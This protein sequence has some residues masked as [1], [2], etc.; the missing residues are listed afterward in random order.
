MKR[1]SRKGRWSLR[2]AAIGGLMVVAII[3]AIAR[4]HFAHAE[5]KAVSGDNWSISMST[6]Y[7]EYDDG[8][9]G[10]YSEWH[11]PDTM[12]AWKST[13]T[14]FIKFRVTY[15]NR[16]N[17]ESYA[18]GEL[19][20]VVKNPIP[21]SDSNNRLR[22]FTDGV[23]FGANIPGVTRY[24][25]T[26]TNYDNSAYYND[27][28]IFTNAN[29][30]EANTNMEGSFDIVFS[31][32]QMGAGAV[33]EFEN[34]FNIHELFTSQATLNDTVSSNEVSF[35]FQ[36]DF[37]V[38][39]R[40]SNFKIDTEVEKIESYDLIDEQN[41]SDYTWVIYNY[42]GRA[43][44]TN[45]GN[46][47]CTTS[48]P[49]V[50]QY[51]R[52][53]FI[54]LSSYHFTTQLPEGAVAYDLGGN[55]LIPDANNYVDVPIEEAR[56]DAC[57]RSWG[58]AYHTAIIGYPKS[59]YNADD[60]TNVISNKIE[61]RGVYATET[62]E[63]ALAQR[64]TSVDLSN[65]G[66]VY[67]GNDIEATKEYVK[68]TSAVNENIDYEMFSSD[69]KAGRA[70]AEFSNK[71]TIKNVSSAY[72]LRIGD[73]V[74]FYS[75]NGSTQKLG[76]YDYYFTRVGKPATVSGMNGEY[77][78]PNTHYSLYVRRRGQSTFEKYGDY[79]ELSN[80]WTGQYIE[81]K[82]WERIVGWYIEIDNLNTSLN[83]TEFRTTVAFDSRSLPDSGIA[84]NFNFIEIERNGVIVNTPNESSYEGGMTR[85]DIMQY[86][87]DTYGRLRQHAV[88]SVSWG[89]F[90]LMDINHYTNPDTSILTAPNYNAT[91]DSFEGAISVVAWGHDYSLDAF[92]DWSQIAGAYQEKDARTYMRYYFLLPKG[93]VPTM[94]GDEMVENMR[95]FE[96]GN[97]Q[98]DPC[99]KMRDYRTGEP[100]LSPS[101][102]SSY[103]REH[104]SVAVLRNW[105]GTGQYLIRVNTDFSDKP[106]T[107]YNDYNAG[108]SSHGLGWVPIPYRVSYDDYEQYGDSYTI[109]GF[110]DMQGLESYDDSYN[111]IY[112]YSFKDDGTGRTSDPGDD[113][114]YAHIVD[115]DDDGDTEEY[116]MTT[117]RVVSL[118]FASATVQDVQ[119]T[120][121]GDVDN[122][123]VT[124]EAMSSLGGDYN[125]RLRV[126]SGSNQ[127]K[128]V[129]LY[130]T[131]ENAFGE[132]E[133]WNGA[134]TGIDTSFADAQTDAN[135]NPVHVKT[136]WSSSLNP[137]SLSEDPSSW[138]EYTTSTD[139]TQVRSLAF[140]FLNQ[141][142]QPATLPSDSNTY[143]IINM[144][145]PNDNNISTYAYNG[146][147][148]EWK[149]IDPQTGGTA[150][151]ITG[152]DSN[153]TKI[154]LD[155]LFDIHV[156]NRWVD[157]DNERGFRPDSVDFVLNRNGVQDATHN[158][159]TTSNNDSFDFEDLHLY[160]EDHYVVLKPSVEHYA[161]ESNYD[162]ATHTYVFTHTL[163]DDEDI[164]IVHLWE[165][166]NNA[167][168]TRPASVT[169]TLR[170]GESPITRTS[171][172]NDWTADFL[173]LDHRNTYVLD[174]VSVTDYDTTVEYD[175]DTQTYTYTS[176]LTRK[177]TVNIQ[178]IWV[179]DD[180]ARN[181]RP[182]NVDYV[183]SKTGS[184]DITHTELL[185]SGE[186]TSFVGLPLIDRA[187]YSVPDI[188]IEHYSTTKSCS[189]G[190]NNELN[191]VFTSTLLDD[192]DIHVVHVWDDLN[193]TYNLR[194]DS[195]SY[196]L[197]KNDAVVDTGSSEADG[198]TTDFVNL[199]RSDKSQYVVVAD[200]IPNYTTTVS[201]DSEGLVYTFTSKLSKEFKVNIQQVW[202]DNNNA[203]NL[204]PASQVYTLKKGEAGAQTSTIS[205]ANASTTSF[206]GLP[207]IDRANYSVPDI[208]I[209]HYSTTKSCT[210]GDDFEINCVFT[211][212]LQ[213]DLDIHV[214]HNWVDT[215]FESYRPSSVSYT[216]QKGNSTVGTQNASNSTS[217]KTDFVNLHRPDASQYSIP[218]VSVPNY[219]TTKSFDENTMTYTFTSTLN[220]PL[221]I[222]VK[223][224]WVDNNNERGLRPNSIDYTLKKTGASDTVQS[225]NIANGDSTTDFTGLQLLDKAKF[226]VPD[227]TVQYYD[228][229]KSFDESTMT[230]TFKSTLRA[231][232]ITVK[233]VWVDNNNAKGLR[234]TTT[235]Y[236]LVRNN[237]SESAHAMNTASGDSQFNFT[238]VPSDLVND[239]S[240]TLA[241]F[242]HYST[243][244]SVSDDKLTYTF[245]STLSD[246]FAITINQI[247]DDEDN[248]RGLRPELTSYN[249]Q[250]DGSTVD[251]KEISAAANG[252]TS[253]A[254]LPLIDE[255]KY[256]VLEITVEHY[257]TTVS[258]DAAT[259]TYTFT[260]VLQDNL[261]IQIVHIW[262]DGDNHFELRPEKV[263]YKLLKNDTEVDSKEVSDENDWQ[264]KVTNLHMP[265][266]SQYLVPTPEIENYTTTVE[267][268]PD[269]MTYTFT[270]ALDLVPVNIKHVWDDGDNELDS[271][272]DEVNSELTRNDE[273]EATHDVDTEE[274]EDEFTI[275]QIPP[276]L[277]DEY[278]AKLSPIDYYDTDVEFDPDTNTYIFVS[279]L[280]PT[281]IHVRN[282]WVDNS[283]ENRLRPDTLEFNLRYEKAQ[284]VSRTIDT[285]A[286]DDSFAFENL[287]EFKAKKYDVV[288]A[289]EIENYTTTVEFDEA[290]KTYVFTHTVVLAGNPEDAN[291]GTGS[292]NSEDSTDL[293]NTFANNP[294]ILILALLGFGSVAAT[295]LAITKRRQ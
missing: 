14:K 105:H 194:P 11:I 124:D 107:S 17:S 210:D 128:N 165:D 27:D 64:T 7:E 146:F 209:E 281:E 198:W 80:G 147:R 125:Y 18:P 58:T 139:K 182:E 31:V 4:N 282:I 119:S 56:I 155:R 53:P 166:A 174:D 134:F 52:G 170:G 190:E 289:Q 192:L 229:V 239:Y 212:K 249:L 264:T 148:S 295:T 120:V 156:V 224:V 62:D 291:G 226:S 207:L 211:S 9:Y 247:W 36:R 243:Q 71:F 233:H 202:D 59:L 91:A 92:N 231:T 123:F 269:T 214:V 223:Q 86:D 5:T 135:G 256:G 23:S 168:N 78:S 114:T 16:N 159:V 84:Y 41:P 21:N 181:L 199:R 100:I 286:D 244:L 15:S 22:I 270:S 232:P 164:H 172:P 240:V 101:E 248:A 220:V 102:W 245:T 42:S 208:E 112:R 132:N 142:N 72:K 235:N 197:K 8:N 98:Y 30:I 178:Q 83:A 250:K 76:D 260:S 230:Y 144:Q 47:Y 152:I 87:L 116:L 13:D 63:S 50:S 67:D 140:E 195:A 12:Q 276:A 274:N 273:T 257:A 104:T 3:G 19:Q 252:S 39:W 154:N 205:F 241:P 115:I 293:P 173:N 180:N 82:S 294:V 20:I 95:V 184:A 33:P 251:T 28:F 275:A 236:D 130:D 111:S 73:D 43:L 75:A 189:D 265:D 292:K 32:H 118:V 51:S 175:S 69:I 218:D 206:T 217:W 193:N 287:L 216:L 277:L 185:P 158:L 288:L 103:V 45:N 266:K 60:G 204:R 284:E 136:Y 66:F 179:D 49:S 2:C 141:N 122:V 219:T 186:T 6:A 200:A 253:F 196:K 163:V 177:F 117:S 137:G 167:Y 237:V 93:M 108:L 261:D 97:S 70:K 221:E 246:K 227:I 238:N 272:P 271:R 150:A 183:L 278:L 1:L 290:T 110:A 68:M 131:I 127:I 258:Y 77:V 160:D 169:Y 79:S 55:K 283:N 151:E 279:K 188:E 26:L 145:A 94:T 25:W 171:T 225:I 48:D 222:H 126:R 157:R 40:K 161:T 280:T 37:K 285:D 74:L 35:D 96:C 54:G 267:F 99:R 121:K 129:V 149:A 201:T 57:E 255:A 109:Y 106:Y 24:D 44:D 162:E 90:V 65:Y 38:T 34:E 46:S 113:A 89:P 81:F 133:H 61:A 259:H 29:T 176:K 213:D 262:D 203:R 153:I 268:D 10:N 85:E 215:G 254:D 187:K 228:T 263:D 242:D 191:C 138:Q 234:P 143:V 88:G